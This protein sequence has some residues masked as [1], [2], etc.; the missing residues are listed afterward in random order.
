M[1]VAIDMRLDQGFFDAIRNTYLPIIARQQL[2]IPDSIIASLASFYGVTRII[3]RSFLGKLIY[4]MTLKRLTMVIFTVEAVSGLFM[5]FA[6]SF[7]HLAII[8]CLA[9]FC[10]IGL[11]IC[12]LLVADISTYAERGFANAAI[13]LSGSS[14]SL[15]QIVAVPII[16]TWGILS[17]FPFASNM[18]SNNIIGGK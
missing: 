4:K 7:Y 1:F 18:S 17:V 11:P 6:S 5:L 16:E 14:G 9:G 15:A 12:S 3:V 2:F 8:Q 13:H 10:S